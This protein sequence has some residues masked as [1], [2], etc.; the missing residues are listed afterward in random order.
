MNTDCFM[1]DLE[2]MLLAERG[3]PAALAEAHINP[4]FVKVLRLLGFDKRYVRGQGAYLYDDDD[5]RYL[6]CLAGYGTFGCGRNH[7]VIRQAIQQAMDLELPNLLHMGIAS[8]SGLL[9]RELIAVAPGDLETVFFT[10][11]GSEGVE[12]ALKYARV[13][14]GRS[15]IIHCEKSFHGLTLGALS[16]NGHEIFR[17]GFGPFLPEICAVP[18]N[19]LEA[20]A[21]ELSRGDVAGLIVEPIQGEGVY[22]PRDDYLAGALELCRKHGAIF[23]ADEVQTGLGR[24]G[25][26][27]ACEHWGIEPDI[28]I[29]A[30]ALSGGYVPA[31]A[32]LSKRWI[33]NRVFSSLE[34]SVVHS[35]T[36][37]EN[38]LAMAAGLATLYVLQA[39][40]LVDNAAAMGELLAGGLRDVGRKYEMFRE[41]RGKG[42]M[43]GLEFGP[44][45]SVS[46]KIG[47]NL[48]HKLDRSLFCQVMLI[49]LLNEHHVLAQVAGHHIDVI[50]L[51]P[52]L[53]ISE[54]DVAH[55]VQA[56]DQVLASSHRFPGP[57]WELGKRFAGTAFG[58]GG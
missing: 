4:A 49:P 48:L 18:Y 28:L 7:P 19:D 41:V 1:L 12:T 5:N 43:L 17:G 47:W 51:I 45:Q 33:H 37:S 46:L 27:F 50:K 8:L 15:R 44:P 2:N 11:S 39:E 40:R 35:S 3:D 25:K 36:F 10:S 14:T 20:L 21:R 54:D 53:V 55:L 22:M 52:T 56:F 13:A 30:K 42:L 9:A 6:D 32:V 34:R 26:M 16:V 24:T 57:I 23:I 38:D 31:G 29:T 58:I